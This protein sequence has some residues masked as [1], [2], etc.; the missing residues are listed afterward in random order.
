MRYARQ[1]EIVYEQALYELDFSPPQT[2]PA[3]SKGDLFSMCGAIT[4]EDLAECREIEILKKKDFGQILLERALVNSYQIQSGNSLIELHS[5]DKL[6]AYQAAKIMN[7]I[8]SKDEQFETA[9]N[10]ISPTKAVE[11]I[12]ISYANLVVMAGIATA[13]ELSMAGMI[14]GE[15]TKAVM[16]KLNQT[17]IADYSILI[18]GSR[19]HSV[20]LSGYLDTEETVDILKFCHQ[21]KLNLDQSLKA[22]GAY[23]PAS[24]QWLWVK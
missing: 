19:L 9:L 11:K 5:K 17:K 1:K 7:L 2:E 21:N 3:L 16:E 14:D 6:K 24:A 18:A 8:C 12:D 13:N 22:L 15:S 4:K 10:T 20:L 23:I